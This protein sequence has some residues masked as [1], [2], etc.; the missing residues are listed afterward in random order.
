MKFYV[1]GRRTGKTESTLDW[2]LVDPQN[3]YVVFPNTAQATMFWRAFVEKYIV[4]Y[5][6]RPN[7]VL[8][9]HLI[10]A[11]RLPTDLRGLRGGMVAIDNLDMIIRHLCGGL[12][13]DFVTA[14]GDLV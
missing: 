10:S 3:R 5:N 11:E 4:R 8:R 1:T 13:V 12:D 14:T 7:G 6:L 9:G 2:F